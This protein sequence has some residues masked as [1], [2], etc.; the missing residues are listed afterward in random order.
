MTAE[1]FQRIGE[2]QSYDARPRG[3]LSEDPIRPLPAHTPGRLAVFGHMSSVRGRRAGDGRPSGRQPASGMSFSGCCW[4]GCGRR[5][6]WTSPGPRS[7]P[8]MCGASGAVPPQAPCGVCRPRVRPR[9]PPPTAARADR[10]AAPN[11]PSGAGPLAGR[12]G[13][14]QLL[15]PGARQPGP[16]IGVR[17]R[18]GLDRTGRRGTMQGKISVENFLPRI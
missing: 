6:G 16:M 11:L 9:H 10:L 7:T 18:T 17:P 15:H 8:R 14:R 13:V 5:T 3:A 4:T 2:D 12:P 1:R